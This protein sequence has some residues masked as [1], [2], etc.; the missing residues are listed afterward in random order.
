METEQ[1]I[2]PS[3]WASYLVNGDASGLSNEEREAC[4]NW[5]AFLGINYHCVDAEPYGFVKIHDAFDFMP[6][7]AECSTYT[8]HRLPD[9]D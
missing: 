4:D 9:I 2:A 5:V 8:F 1:F 7:A 3:Y 6:Y